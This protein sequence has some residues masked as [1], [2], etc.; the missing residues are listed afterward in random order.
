M[1]SGDAEALEGSS[2]FSSVSESEGESSLL[3]EDDPE[4]VFSDLSDEELLDE[5]EL[6]ESGPNPGLGEEAEAEAKLPPD[7]QKH[8]SFLERMS[9]VLLNKLSK[10]ECTSLL[11]DSV[12]SEFFLIDGD[13]L[14]IHHALNN[15][16]CEGQN[17]HFFYLVEQFLFDI[18]QKGAKYVIVFFKDAESM[19]LGSSYY[20]SLR[21]ALILHLKNNT[22]VPVYTE[23][24][25][26]F[27]FKWQAFVQEHYPYFILINDEAIKFPGNKS[28]SSYLLKIFI[29]HT[30]GNKINV[31]LTSGMHSNIRRLYGYYVNSKVVLTRCRK[32]HKDMESAHQAIV[33]FLTRNHT[34]F[35]LGDYQNSKSV[36]KEVQQDVAQLQHLWPD[37]FDIRSYICVVSCSVALKCYMRERAETPNIQAMEETLTFQEVVDLCRMYCAHVALLIHL[38]LTK[39]AQKKINFKWMKPASDFLQLLHLC[40]HFILKTLDTTQNRRGDMMHL[41]DLNDT[42]L[43]TRVALCSRMTD[44]T[45]SSFQLGEVIEEEYKKLWKIMSSSISDYDVGKAFPLQTTS[46]IMVQESENSLA[47]GPSEVIPEVGLIPV[48]ITLVDEYAGR[49]LKDFPILSSDSS[50][51][52]ALTENKEFANLVDWY[53]DRPLSDDYER[54]RSSAFGEKTNDPWVRKRML[55]NY[56]KLVRFHRF[57][58]STLEGNITKNIITNVQGVTAVAPKST[59]VI[60]GKGKKLPPK[61]K[62]DIIAEENIRKKKEKEDQKQREQWTL[63][64]K[65]IMKMIQEN[66]DHGIKKLEEFLKKCSG[67]SVKLIAEMDVLENC[68]KIW[69][70]HC[71]ITES[72][73][74]NNII[75]GRVMKRIHNILDKY[76]KQMDKSQLKQIASYLKELGFNKLAQTIPD[77]EQK[78]ARSKSSKREDKFVVG[79]DPVRFQLQFMGAYLLRD[80][81]NDPDPRVTHFIP[82]TWQRELLDAVDNNESA[83]IVAPTSSGKTY[84]SYYCMEKVLRD[85]D[86]GVLVYVAPTKALVNQVVATVYN[87]FTKTLPD[88]MVVCGVL[89]RDYRQD[90]LNCQILITIPQCLEMLMLTAQRQAWVKRL[91]YVIFDEVHCI[92]QEVGAEVWEHL[93]V[94]IR[95]PFLALSAT[96]SKPEVLANWLQTV[97]NYWQRTEK[98]MENPVKVSGK[99]KQQMKISRDQ[100]SYRVKLVMYGERYNDLEKYMCSSNGSA[101][102]FVSYHPCAALT[103]SHIEKYGF[104]ADLSLSPPESLRLYDTMAETWTSWTRVQE[105]NP[106]EYKHFKDK[107]V[108]K[109]SD[110]RKYEAELK[111]ELVKWITSGHRDQAM[112][113]LDKLRPRNVVNASTNMVRQF[114]LLVEALQKENQLPALFFSFSVSLVERLAKEIF[115]HITNKEQVKRGPD[116]A[117]KRIEVENKLRKLSKRA[118]KKQPTDPKES[119]VSDNMVMKETEQEMLHQKLQELRKIP[120]DCTY[121]VESAADRKILDI[122]F[123]RLQQAKTA[124]Q[125]RFY[126]E[127]GIGFHH[128]S[129]NSKGRQAVEMLFRLG[130]ARVVTATGTLALGINMPCKTVVFLD[131]SVL[132]DALQYRQMSGRAGRRGFDV[133]GNVIFYCV[134]LPKVQRLLKAGVPLLKGQFPLSVSLVLRLMVLAAKSDDRMDAEAKTLSLLHHPLFCHDDQKK[135]LALKLYFL[136]SL[137]F[138]L[139]EGFLDLNGMPQGFA[140]LVTHLHQHEPANFIFVSFLVKGLFHK[141]CSQPDTSARRGATRFSDEV[142]E[143]LLLILANIFGRKYLPSCSTEKGWATFHQS[144]V[145]LDD[146]PEEFAEAVEKYN[147]NIQDIFGCFFL[148]ASKQADM[149]EEFHLPLSRISYGDV[150]IPQGSDTKFIAQVTAPGN[151]PTTAVSPFACLSG[152]TNLDLFKINDLDSITLR[153]IEVCASNIPVLNLKKYDQHGRRMPLNAYV[154]DFYRHGSLKA[155]LNDNMLHLGE[156]YN[157]LNDFQLTLASISTSF[158]EMCDDK[159]DIVLL[160]FEQLRDTFFQKFE[161]IK[162]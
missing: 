2:G 12:E 117:K 1:A 15:T 109:K 157:V 144:K 70:E 121:A 113:V 147:R 160:A 23:F 100:K 25:N 77:I 28:M 75:A 139:K 37:G 153:T 131:D 91:K 86:D 96:I 125:L 6:S 103:A 63:I 126:L 116:D 76:E 74:K 4:E 99:K 104:P 105:L 49:I 106:E 29:F 78:P 142:M 11:H 112:E 127:R 19:W 159:N 83:V 32:I 81:R 69:V 9:D 3:G 124:N 27:S 62:A 14:M 30:L 67:D 38:P 111:E 114:P 94:M 7:L 151:H 46:K 64:S 132:L 95:C 101:F 60:S 59:N 47:E 48:N 119:N 61:K 141:I 66:F 129:L 45:E 80:E 52:T 138:L 92:G 55:K 79:V 50:V 73:K 51:V 133:I 122:I 108:I 140:G 145:F 128:P 10:A 120:P 72:T 90:A 42:L 18:I 22:D 118:G 20:L 155:L 161:K 85:S 82:D 8:Q 97:K 24:S 31:A 162:S 110:V 36:L 71:Q 156:A 56:Q 137:Q 13:S 5:A 89:T 135:Q 84:A 58:G 98:T 102:E 136:F 16:L 43:L 21:S 34:V 107:I 33:S 148:S 39:R 41:C 143:Y 87:R 130:F 152:I 57:Y 93:L 35:F 68:F 149:V 54:T 115:A 158:K 53:P 65:S 44:D 40:Q 26:C 134:P 123:Q 150:Q 17:L 154:L 88:G 146:L